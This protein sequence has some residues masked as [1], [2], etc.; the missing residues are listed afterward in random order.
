[1]AHQAR[2]FLLL[3]I[4][5]IGFSVLG[6]VYG[7]GVQ[8]AM[9]EPDLNESGVSGDDLGFTKIYSLVQQNFATPVNADKAIYSGAIPGMASALDPHTSFLDPRAYRTFLDEQKGHYF[10]VGM[11]VGP[12]NNKTVVIAPFPGSPAYRVGIRPGD[13]LVTINDK[14][15]D[16]LNTTEIADLLKGPRDTA[17]KIVV[18]REGAPDYLTFTITR[19]EINRKSVPDGF[20]LGQGIGYIKITG[21]EDDTS[22]G[23]DEN[24]KRLGPDQLQ[25]LVL[26]LRFNPGGLLDEAVDVAGAFLPRGTTVVSARGR[27]YPPKTYTVR[28]GARGRAYPIVVLVNQSSASAAEIVSGALQDHDRAWIMGET[29]FGKGLV[30]TVFPLSSGTAIALTTA[31]FYTPSGRLIQRD[32]SHQSFFDYYS[33]KDGITRNSNDVKMTDSGRTV[34]G[35]GGITPDEEYKTQPLDRLESNLYRTSIFSFTRWY[36]SKHSSKLP[37]GWM[38]DQDVLESLHDYLVDHDVDFKETD[39][40]LDQDWIKRQ[41]TKEMYIYA[42]DVDA[43]EKIFAQTDPEVKKAME[44]MPKAEALM[45]NARR[46]MAKRRQ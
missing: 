11:E 15:T 24:L 26:D 5:V 7:N 37:A 43:S 21:F 42:F 41:L 32:Y 13:V 18:S 1:M 3:P 25:G 20:M 9:D 45:E 36:F 28:N 23:L 44:S 46:V 30:Q 10:G 16:N 14:S 12:R 6:G 8:A 29:T 22:R 35:G 27:A 4:I 19:E 31:H 2:S 40:M 39:F 38:P 33:H 34:Y 17:V